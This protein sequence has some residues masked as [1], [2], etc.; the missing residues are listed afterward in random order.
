MNSLNAIFFDLD[1]TLVYF[2]IEYIKAR[3]KAIKILERNGIPKNKYNLN[4]SI[5]EMIAESK[6]YFSNTLKFDQNKINNIF[7]KVNESIIKIELK[8][9]KKAKPIN[10]IDKLLK[11]FKDKKIKQII[12]T[13]NT[14]KTAEL[15]L[16]KAKLDSYIN[17]IYGRDDVEIAKPNIKHLEPVIKKYN[18]K[19]ENCVIVGDYKIDIELGKNFGC[20]T[21][22]V[23]TNHE[24]NLIE[25]A[26]FKIHQDKL[27]DELIK[28]LQQNFYF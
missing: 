18:L 6:N 26:D 23:I 28:I 17:E 22:G 2:Q 16:K 5:R 24:I 11:Y 19:P 20:K 12:I 4:S 3:K 1:G 13:Y 7:K 9:A 25:N 27:Y 14:H 8:A 21:I 15:T 10:N